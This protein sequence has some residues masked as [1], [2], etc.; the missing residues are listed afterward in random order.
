M[1]KASRKSAGRK[2]D[3]TPKVESYEVLPIADLTIERFQVRKQNT[4]EALD[5]LAAKAKAAAANNAAP[6]RSGAR[7]ASV[8]S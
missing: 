1:A 4:G 2:T 6:V 7:K 5:E 3:N 8:Q